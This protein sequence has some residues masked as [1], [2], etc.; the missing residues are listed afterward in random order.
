MRS[1]L[2]AP[3]FLERLRVASRR[4]RLAGFESGNSST[5]RVS[6]HGHPFDGE[7]VGRC[8]GEHQGTRVDFDLRMLPRM[9][10][11]FAAIILFSIWPGVYF[12][13]ELIAQF[14]P[15]MWRP[16]VTYY[17]YLPLTILPTP[18]LWR[19]VMAKSRR[20]MREHADETLAKITKETEAITQP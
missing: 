12:M 15:G 10:A 16:W 18:F 9:P 14:L 5:F 4:G 13:D 7:L 11:L 19:S 6:A 17:W 20:T 2:T 1:R 3:E 8:T